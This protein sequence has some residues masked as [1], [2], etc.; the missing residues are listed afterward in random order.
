MN[1]SY[2]KFSKYFRIYMKHLPIYILIAALLCCC[3]SR[4]KADQHTLYVSILPL[5]TIVGQIVGDDFEIGVLVPAGASPETFE[6]T[7]K[8][9]IALNSAQLVF[10]V[11]L[12]DFEN[13]LLS[14]IEDTT[15]IV[16]LSAGITP[17]AGSCSHSSHGHHHPHGI[18]PHIW[19]SAR[20]LQRMATNAYSA[21]HMLY[22][23]SVKYTTNYHALIAE[24]QR[25][26]TKIG[27]ALTAGGTTYFIIY[28]PALTYYARDYGIRQVAIEEEGKEPTAKRLSQVI[29][30]ARKDGVK[31]IFYQSQFPASAVAVIAKDIDADYVEIDPLREDV[32]A[33]LSE[34]TSLI[35]QK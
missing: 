1:Y 10:N 4:P 22:P 29:A 12:I 9:F 17:I 19:T 14:K 28:H 6:P 5:R 33:N 21:L 30:Q 23:D 27:A 32:I 24:L 8:Q 13:S 15:K 26:D 31:R 35:T 20:E 3:T 34:I 7:P 2:R 16:N 11:G 25:L 18:D